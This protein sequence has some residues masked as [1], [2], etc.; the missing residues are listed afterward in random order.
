MYSA[1]LLLC[2]VVRSE[3]GGVEEDEGRGES[4]AGGHHDGQQHGKHQF[5]PAHRGAQ[6][7]IN[8]KIAL[9]RD[10]YI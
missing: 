6:Q 3:W 8:V 1:Y 10:I 7:S 2:L 9:G 4:E 5:P